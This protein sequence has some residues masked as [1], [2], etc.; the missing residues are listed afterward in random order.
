MSTR[1]PQLGHLRERARPAKAPTTSPTI[2]DPTVAEKLQGGLGCVRPWE[3]PE[4]LEIADRQ[5]QQSQG[6]PDG[7]SPPRDLVHAGLSPERASV[8]SVTPQMLRRHPLLRLRSSQVLRRASA[9]HSDMILHP[10]PPGLDPSDL[11]EH[12]RGHLYLVRASPEPSIFVI[13][14]ISIIMITLTMEW[15]ENGLPGSCG[16]SGTSDVTALQSMGLAKLQKIY[17]DHGARRFGRSS[18]P[19]ALGT[20]SVE[21]AASFLVECC[22]RQHGAHGTNRHTIE[23][24]VSLWSR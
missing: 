24:G 18:S 9:S 17:R 11:M 7:E 3:Q 20:G 2:D 4:V 6:P 1:P 19:S 5:R 13:S 14:P 8:A 22:R 21:M 16:I 23:E 12:R 15:I 10:L